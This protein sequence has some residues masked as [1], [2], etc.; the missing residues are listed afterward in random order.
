MPW[1]G[2]G[3]Y[4]YLTIRSLNSEGFKDN[5]S[6]ALKCRPEYLVMEEASCLQPENG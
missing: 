3:L 2:L 4:S 6:T 5:A 1:N